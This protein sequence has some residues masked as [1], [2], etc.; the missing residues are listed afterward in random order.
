MTMELDTQLQRIVKYLGD[1]VTVCYNVDEDSDDYNK[2]YPFAT[3]YSR[4]AMSTAVE[5]LNKII[6]QIQSIQCEEED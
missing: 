3:G 6:T 1:A 4:S 5:D 2:T